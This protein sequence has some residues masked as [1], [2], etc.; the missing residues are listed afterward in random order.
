MSI[1][2]YGQDQNKS[3]A[4]KVEAEAEAEVD[5]LDGGSCVDVLKEKALVDHRIY[6]AKVSFS[7]VQANLCFVSE[8]DGTLVVINLPIQIQY[9]IQN[10]QLKTICTID[11]K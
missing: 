1:A 4:V 3:N 8:Q 10:G 2:A 11:S 7:Q 9:R 6:E 5:G